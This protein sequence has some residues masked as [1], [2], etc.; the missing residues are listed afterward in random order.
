MYGRQI[1]AAI[2]RH[3]NSKENDMPFLLQATSSRKETSN[4]QHWSE[5]MSTSLFFKIAGLATVSAA[6]L[7]AFP[8]MAQEATPDTWTHVDSVASRADVRAAAVAAHS[9]SIAVT[10][11]ESTVFSLPPSD[12]SLTREEVLEQVLH[13][14]ARVAPD[15]FNIGG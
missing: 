14:P 8:S 1:S 3:R 11:G 2:S 10:G 5:I 12:S 7:I 4:P 9:S 15:P 13:A 6:A